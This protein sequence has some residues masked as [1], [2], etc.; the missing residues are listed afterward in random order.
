ML[1]AWGAGALDALGQAHT[2]QTDGLVPQ[3]LS[4]R[5]QRWDRWAVNLPGPYYLQVVE[6]LFRGNQLAKSQF[7]ALGRV[8][9]LS[10]VK[11]PIYL[12]AGQDDEVTPPEQVLALSRH[13]GTPPRSIQSA[14]PLCGHLSLFMGAQTLTTE[15]PNVCAW[16]LEQSLE[17][18]YRRARE[19]EGVSSGRS[20]R[21]D[22]TARSLPL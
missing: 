20:D 4:E 3:E 11:A 8:L 12:L 6:Q 14:V 21:F 9:D 7:C 17:G 1:S 13:V 2:L 15:W 18:G 16:L 5:F 19:R 10:A 22:T